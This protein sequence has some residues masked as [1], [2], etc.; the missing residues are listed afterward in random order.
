MA[1]LRSRGNDIKK[2]AKER[3]ASCEKFELVTR[4]EWG[5]LP[6]KE[7]PVPIDLPVNMCFVHHTAGN[8]TCSDLQ[9]CII[10]VKDIQMFHMENRGQ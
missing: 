4:E 1:H 9:G 2:V 6:P 5:A 7:P 10:Q 8:W 3:Q